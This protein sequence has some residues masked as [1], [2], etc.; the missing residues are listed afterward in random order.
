MLLLRCFFH[1]RHR[2]GPNCLCEVAQQPHGKALAEHVKE[3]GSPGPVGSCLDPERPVFVSTHLTA[4]SR[5]SLA[6]GVSACLFKPS[7]VLLGKTK[8]HAYLSGH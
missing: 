6:G 1:G 3:V 5:S 8:Q 4:A 7:S 2:R